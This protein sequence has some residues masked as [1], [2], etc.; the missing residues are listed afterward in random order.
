MSETTSQP[1]SEQLQAA[2]ENFNKDSDIKIRPFLDNGSLF[3][4][5]DKK[6]WAEQSEFL[7]FVE[8]AKIAVRAFLKDN[9]GVEV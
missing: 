8:S 3:I 7:A 5:E 2:A 1:T 9:Y 4:E 6:D